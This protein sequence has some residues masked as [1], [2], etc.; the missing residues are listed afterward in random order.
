MNVKI[1]FSVFRTL[2]IGSCLFLLLPELLLLLLGQGPLGHHVADGEGPQLLLGH[3][4]VEVLAAEF[5]GVHG[6]RTRRATLK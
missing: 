4:L 5:V 1:A 3:R 2:Q 6:S